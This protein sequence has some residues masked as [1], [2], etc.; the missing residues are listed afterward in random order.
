MDGVGGPVPRVFLFPLSYK[1][2]YYFG[3]LTVIQQRLNTT[4]E[5]HNI[6]PQHLNTIQ[7]SESSTLKTID[8]I[9]HKNVF[10]Y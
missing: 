8:N 1:N 5:L 3:H 4:H 10:D 6:L 9:F 7:H 2:N